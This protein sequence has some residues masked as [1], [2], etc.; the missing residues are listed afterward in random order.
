MR[1]LR[2]G[3]MLCALLAFDLTT[4]TAQT[5][6][7]KARPKVTL[8]EVAIMLSS[9]EEE[10]LRTA[11][12][13][14]AMLPAGEVLPLLEERVRS[15]LPFALLE[16]AIDTVVLLGDAAAEPL[17]SELTHHR[18]PT[19]RVRA[20]DALARTGGARTAELATGALGDVESSVRTA[21]AA[22]L[23][24]LG[25]KSGAVGALSRAV[26]RDVAGAAEALG[27]V[28]RPSD[29]DALIALLQRQPFERT[30]A[31]VEP[32]LA[33]DDL[34]LAD[35]LR[36]V[37]A[38]AKLGSDDARAELTRLQSA[39]PKV[40]PPLKRAIAQAATAGGAP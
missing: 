39:L 5:A 1:M 26:D 24:L 22:T 15:G 17:L 37:D 18:R 20:L 30:G 23:G 40:A 8:E 27:R 32:L 7:R 19:I 25:P 35:K 28:A 34:P 38:L 31:M 4:A 2:H 9:Q 33:R 36:I 14:A 3:V 12:E 6:P 21:A 11:L 10:E 29:V 16:V 13:S